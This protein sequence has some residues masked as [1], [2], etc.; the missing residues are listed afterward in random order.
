MRTQPPSAA[1]IEQRHLPLALFEH[2]PI[3]IRG[4]HDGRVPEQLVDVFEG[5]TWASRNVAAA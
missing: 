5:Y 4:Q 2:V 1:S 3:G